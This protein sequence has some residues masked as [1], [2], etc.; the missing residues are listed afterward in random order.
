MDISCFLKEQFL[1]LN[2]AENLEPQPKNIYGVSKIA[3]ED[4]CYLFHKQTSIPT[5][6]LRVSR[7]F[8]QPDD[9]DMR[10]NVMTNDNLKVLE[11]SY[12]RVDIRDVVDSCVAAMEKAP[13]IGWGRYVISAPSPFQRD[14][15]TLQRLNSNAGDILQEMFP[16]CTP[17][18]QDKGW[19][20]LS[21]IDRVYDSTK[22]QKEL[23]WKPNFTFEAA[24][25]RVGK[26]EEW[27]S[28]LALK[29]GRRGYHSV[30]TAFYTSR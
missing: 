10:R 6:V 26:G 25:D 15:N 4:V 17:L 5:V 20:F 27:R 2:F 19:K 3:A 21:S 1:T 16:K 11:L 13:E 18:F 24:L 9:D 12:R 30:S 28:Q 8:P 14:Q 29:V 7:F 23:G 22:A